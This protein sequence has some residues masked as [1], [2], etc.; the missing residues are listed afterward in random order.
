MSTF[1][2]RWRALSLAAVL[3]GV[4]LRPS[5]AT[6]SPE[7]VPGDGRFSSY[8][9]FQ[10]RSGRFI[11][12]AGVGKGDVS[13]SIRMRLRVLVLDLAPVRV[14]QI[15]PWVEGDWVVVWAANDALLICGHSDQDAAYEISAHEFSPSG[16]VTHRAATAGE[17][18]IV[19]Q[20]FAAKFGRAPSPISETVRPYDA[21]Q[22][23]GD[24]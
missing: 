19:V 23:D 4:C 3:V 2:K 13:P 24:R 7:A 15:L 1:R 17:R 6:T 14:R 16:E 12:L 21:F 10:S 18:K 8:Q 22:P 9:S 5:G 11:A 20:A